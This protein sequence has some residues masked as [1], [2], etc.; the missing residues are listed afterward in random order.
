MFCLYAHNAVAA[1]L[2]IKKRIQVGSAFIIEKSFLIKRSKKENI[3]YPPEKGNR[4]TTNKYNTLT[5]H[6]EKIK[7]YSCFTINKKRHPWAI[8][9]YSST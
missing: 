2:L 7:L 8:N 5:K 3:K 9:S 6:N 1:V 4:A